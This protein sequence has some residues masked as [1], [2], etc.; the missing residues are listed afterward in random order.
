M[1]YSYL[2]KGFEDSITKILRLLHRLPASGCNKFAMTCSLFFVQ[3]MA[4]MSLLNVLFMDHLV[5]DGHA[6]QFVTIL[7]KT[8]LSELPI[9]NLMSSLRKSNLD[10]RASH[11]FF[12]LLFFFSSFLLL[13][14]VH[15]CDLIAS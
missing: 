9:E 3:Q 2:Q 6:L 8:Y 14:R 13:R 10:D 11:F 5:K 7:F 15:I 4:P 1:F 12:F